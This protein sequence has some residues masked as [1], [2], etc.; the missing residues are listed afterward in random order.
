M[1]DL[2]RLFAS[3]LPTLATERLTL[4]PFAAADA[5]D[6]ARYLSD[7][8]V[9]RKTLSIPHPYPAG[10]ADEFIARQAP[11]WAAAKR[12]VWAITQR[13]DGALVGAVGLH[14]VLA[15][16]KAEV[17]YWIALPAW[18]KGI[19]TEAVRRAIRFGFDEVGL[20]R[21]DAQHYA[22]NPASGRV[23]I[24]AGMKHEGL[25]RSVVIRDGVPRN[26]ELYAILRSDPR[27]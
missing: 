11:D 21:L 24:K 19:A 13:S 15:H 8:A 26:N 25:M 5:P 9:A 17:G 14:F 23:M 22:E 2:D 6:V 3:P 20:N 18:G 1:P 27:P 4:R 12:A 16:L 10:A 7:A